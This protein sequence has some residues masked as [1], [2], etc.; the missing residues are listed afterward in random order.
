MKFKQIWHHCLNHV[1]LFLLL[2]LGILALIYFD[3]NQ[4]LPRF[5]VPK[6]QVVSL[7]YKMDLGRHTRVRRDDVSEFESEL[8]PQPVFL[9]SAHSATIE[10]LPNGALI[11][12]W[13][14]GSHEG[15]PDVK[16]WQSLLQPEPNNEGQ[17]VKN[18]KR[19]MVDDGRVP[20][21]WSMATPVVSPESLQ[22]QLRRFVK[23]VGNPVVYRASDGRLHLFVVSVALGGWS[24]SQL[25]HLISD[26]NGKTWGRAERLI[27]S[28]VFNLSTLD[29]TAP[30]TLVDGG[31][32]LPVYHECIYKYPELL[33]FDRHGHFMGQIRMN[34]QRDLLQP[35]VVV[36]SENSALAFFRND[37]HVNNVLYTQTTHDGGE[38]WSNVRATSFTNQDSSIATAVI[39]DHQL[40]MLHNVGARN[41]L[42]LALSQDGIKW[43]DVYYL[44]NESSGEFSYPAI[45]AHGDTVD[46]VYTWQRKQI[47][48]VRFNLAWL[49]KVVHDNSR[50]Y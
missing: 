35:S 47:K 16:I 37:N 6:K 8:I 24:G 45:K 22:T 28:P 25:N 3:N 9:Q 14:A 29:R 42:A 21:V 50:Q 1:D 2:L 39:G 33:R 10:L 32:Y 7:P 17:I 48:H 30:I 34:D 26:D 13:F 12:L 5:F 31:F 40:L 15:K 27:L 46:I 23:K 19:I 41:K 11:A 18:R 49:D 36:L 20:E 44:E 4:P 38:S 43:H